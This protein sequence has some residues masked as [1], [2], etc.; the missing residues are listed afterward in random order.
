MSNSEEES[1]RMGWGC[2]AA[3]VAIFIGLPLDALVMLKAIEWFLV[4]LGAH[5]ISFAHALGVSLVVSYLKA[6]GQGR[7]LRKST[8]VSENEAY[9]VFVIAHPLFWLGLAWLVHRFIA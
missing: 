6:R 4:P 5:A 7:D 8:P 3:M 1:A 9:I 2:A